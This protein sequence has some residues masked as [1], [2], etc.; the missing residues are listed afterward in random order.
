MGI[1]EI[2]SVEK[3][4]SP[5]IIRSN[6]I[7]HFVSIFNEVIFLLSTRLF[8]L[9]FF[10]EPMRAYNEAETNSIIFLSFTESLELFTNITGSEQKLFIMHVFRYI[11]RQLIAPEWEIPEHN[12]FLIYY[13]QSLL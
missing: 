13:S 9:L 11:P 10:H 5:N 1:D 2:A 12:K 3:G 4:S 6:V 7:F 8:Y